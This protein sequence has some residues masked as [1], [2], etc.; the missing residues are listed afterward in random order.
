MSVGQVKQKAQGKEHEE[1][2]IDRQGLEVAFRDFSTISSQ[3]ID[4]Y[5]LLQGQVADLEG[6]L[7]KSNQERVQVG[8]DRENLANRLEH[9]LDF[10]PGGVVVIDS[11]GVVED[12]NWVATDFLGTSIIGESWSNIIDQNFSPKFD[13]GHEISL[14]DGRR[15][16]IATRS[17]GGKFPNSVVNNSENE[18]TTLKRG[19]IVLLTDQTQTRDLQ[20]RLSRHK[21]LST[22]GKMVAY[23]AHQIRTPL[24]SAMLYGSHLKSPD[25]SVEQRES[26]S[27]RLLNQLKNLERQVSDLLIFA[28]GEQS[29]QTEI[30]AGDF[31]Y[32]LRRELDV[33][34]V[35]E[36]MIVDVVLDEGSKD[37]SFLCNSPSLISA[38]LNLIN[39]AREAG[40]ENQQGKTTQVLVS[41]R[42]LEKSL[43]I[44][45]CDNGPGISEAQL[46][47]VL[48]PFYSTKSK[49]TGLGLA[50]VQAVIK[51]LGGSLAIRSISTGGLKIE[52]VVPLV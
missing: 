2:G 42:T 26:F 7:S 41:A 27:G 40:Q 29:T 34:V 51:S 44:S 48:E 11:R 25:L 35:V 6:K 52:L 49:G 20:D 32:L 14:K 33:S 30:T 46:H 21:R 5:Q 19:Q 50:V 9:L 28:K 24:S 37:Q 3:L 8:K 36:G 18:E 45:V 1:V 17:L 22:M 38:I 31:F 12:C 10:L 16:S 47:K 39:N 23:L 13:D 43:V 15:L 4:S